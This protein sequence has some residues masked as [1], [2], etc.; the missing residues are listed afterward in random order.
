LLDPDVAL[1]LSVE[2][3]IDFAHPA[4]SDQGLDLVAADLFKRR[5]SHVSTVY[6]SKP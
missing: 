2:G 4:P 5:Q 6:P 1:E 3:A